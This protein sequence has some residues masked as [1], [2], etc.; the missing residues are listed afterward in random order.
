MEDAEPDARDEVAEVIEQFL[1]IN[2][3]GIGEI[4]CLPVSCFLRVILLLQAVNQWCE[5]LQD[6][7]EINRIS[8]LASPIC[9]TL[10]D[11]VGGKLTDNLVIQI[12]SLAII[13]GRDAHQDALKARIP[14]NIGDEVGY[15]DVAFFKDLRVRR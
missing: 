9:A 7:V 6:A 10:D 14:T 4:I 8:N 5:C 1:H 11:T 13:V 2:R 12:E 3:A 15:V